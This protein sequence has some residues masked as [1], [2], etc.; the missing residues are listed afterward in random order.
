MNRFMT[1]WFLANF[2][3]SVALYGFARTEI[4]VS[5]GKPI[6]QSAFQVMET[7]LRPHGGKL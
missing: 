7:A 1:I 4:T 5:Y 2:I 3:S 6:N